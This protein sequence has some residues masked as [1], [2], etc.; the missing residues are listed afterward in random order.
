MTL[1]RIENLFISFGGL[2]ALRDISLQ[3]EKGVILG[4]TGPNGSGKTTLFNC[5]NGIHKPDRGRIFFREQEIQGRRPDQVS[6]MGIAR[7][8]QKVE[9]FTQLNTMENLMIGR[10]NH[11]RTGLLRGAVMWGK[12]SFAGGE[13]IAHRKKVEEIID[14][15]DLRSVR[16]EAAENLPHNARKRVELGRALALEPDLLLLDE[17]CMGMDPQGKQD[18]ILRIKEI[19]SNMGVTILLIEHDMKTIMDI[20]DRMLV[21]G[22]GA[23]IAEGP[24]DEVINH[25][26]VRK[27]HL[28]EER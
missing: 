13:E 3:V 16:D 10:H 1:L 18:M 24:P 22:F 25:P 9:L 26:A 6:R 15:L 4:V 23:I 17:P 14:L 11:I 5:I 28:V 8:Y 19:R 20:S 12:R 21:L 27:L 7:T 2:E